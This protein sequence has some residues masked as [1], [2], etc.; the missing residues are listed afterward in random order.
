MDNI[1]LYVSGDSTVIGVIKKYE[2]EIKKET[3]A[4][5]VK[6]DDKDAN[7]KEANINGLKLS[8]DVKKVTK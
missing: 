7:Y 5:S 8:M 6:Y 4:I 1:E 2:D 3:L